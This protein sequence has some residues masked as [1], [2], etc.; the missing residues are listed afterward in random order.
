M[1]KSCLCF[2]NSDDQTLN[3]F[4]FG[5]WS[6]W[7]LNFLFNASFRKYSG[8]L[9]VNNKSIFLKIED[10]YG[11]FENR[12]NFIYKHAVSKILRY[13][14]HSALTRWQP[15]DTD[16]PNGGCSEVRVGQSSFFSIG[17]PKNGWSKPKFISDRYT[18]RNFAFCS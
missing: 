2:Q 15:R 10:V 18:T 8:C 13:F 16:V 4:Y 17:H 5:D 7:N 6:V 14:R 3:H 9:T 11:F 12:S 1:W